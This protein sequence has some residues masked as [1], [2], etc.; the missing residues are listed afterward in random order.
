MNETNIEMDLACERLAD[1][2]RVNGYRVADA[3]RQEM[4][5]NGH[6]R[7]TDNG[8]RAPRFGNLTRR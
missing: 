7:P 3:W 6:A 4:K 1:A 2:I 5:S 8:T